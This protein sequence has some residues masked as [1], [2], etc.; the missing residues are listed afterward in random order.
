MILNIPSIKNSS[1]F[2]M[3]FCDLFPAYPSVGRNHSKR[4]TFGR[5]KYKPYTYKT[6][7]S[8]WIG[9]IYKTFFFTFFTILISCSPL[10]EKQVEPVIIDETLIFQENEKIFKGTGRLL[11]Q[12]PLFGLNSTELYIL[13]AN[14]FHADSQLILHSH[15]QGFKKG[16]G[17]KIFF[18]REENSLLI[19]AATPGYKKQSLQREENFFSGNQ[20]LYVYVKVQ[21]GIKDLIRIK[22][23]NHWSNPTGYLKSP[24]AFMSDQNLIADSLKQAFYSK[25]KGILWGLELH[26]IHL[27]EILR[28]SGNRI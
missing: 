22:I 25:G 8:K 2:G 21:N 12:K 27:L 7:N 16:N 4:A 18:I 10:D 17:I 14:F 24:S 28:E 13:R 23:W 9:I 1:L 6:K 15:F 5:L 19:E 26:K 20:E 11:F 3:I